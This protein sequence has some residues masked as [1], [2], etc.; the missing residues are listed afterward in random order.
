[1]KDMS[2][3]IGRPYKFLGDTYE[4]FDCIGAIKLYY[5]ENGWPLVETD[6]KPIDHDWYAKDKFRL[7]RYFLKHFDKVTDADL[8]K[9][10]ELILFGINGES[11]V[12]VMIDSYGRFLST[13]P[14]ISKFNGGISFVDRL[15]FWLNMKGVRF[16]SGFRRRDN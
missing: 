6:G 7:A 4:G 11:H 16:I 9:D 10:G 14:P 5:R 12:G 8:L 2:R 3:F 13:F 15:K 1:M